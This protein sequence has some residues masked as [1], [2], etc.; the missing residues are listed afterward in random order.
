MQSDKRRSYEFGPFL[1]DESERQLY[2]DQQP[3][4]LEPK[5]L[6]TLLILIE[7]K[8]RLVFKEEIM[9]RVWPDSFVEEVNLNRNI[10]MLRKALGETASEPVYIETVPKR[11][12]RFSADVAQIDYD[13]TSVILEKRYSAEIIT[14]EEIASSETSEQPG[15]HTSQI[16]LNHRGYRLSPALLAISAALAIALIAAIVLLLSTGGSTRKDAHSTIRTIAVLPFRNLDP[17]ADEHLGMGL[18]DVLITRL[19]N[20]KELDV[21]PTSSI[22]AFEKQDAEAARVGRELQTDAV[23]EGTIQRTASKVRVTVRLV[24]TSD[25]SSIWAAQ[26]DKPLQ[27]EL[28]L[29]DEIALELVDALALNL[30]GNVRDRLTRRYTD[31]ADAYQSYLKGRYHWNKRNPA[32]MIEAE[33]L[34]RNAIDK[35]PSFALA[36]VGLADTL[37]PRGT[38]G[39]AYTAV[40]K[41]LELDPNIAEAHAT[42]GFLEMFYF[43]RWDTAEQSFKRAIDLN[44]GYATA[45]HWYA[46]LLAIEG[47]TKE[48]QSELRR[49][50]EIDPL[51][52]NLLAD[53]GQLH[54]FARDYDKAV[55]YCE[56]ALA[57]YPDFVFAHEYLYSIYLQKAE[58]N[59]AIDQILTS[60]RIQCVLANAS[61]QQKLETEAYL[62]RLKREYQ[63]GG[64]RGYMSHRLSGIQ[65]QD[66]SGLYVQATRYAFLG[67]KEKAL[68]HLERA[69]EAKGFLTAFVKADPVFDGLRSDPRYQAIL[70]RMGLS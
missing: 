33:R 58:Y 52:Y 9:R 61:E 57:V 53:L 69:C 22:L 17:A 19:S 66:S 4:A 34:F 32:S 2:R 15:F 48:A 47:K 7:N 20:I 26:Y 59:K 36:F 14:E 37:A 27:D 8:G 45:H 49:A 44:P 21:R 68:E 1:L 41:A 16:A 6:D 38:P 62:E 54:Y 46:T 30:S 60:D 24:K 10:S 56:K 43:W 11:G 29:Q 67:D 25:N 12:Y 31:S 55:E 63:R 64:I 70:R 65:A 51:S 35:D 3:I 39:G 18:S 5:V 50:L 42:R 40:Q 23:L 28:W 13:E